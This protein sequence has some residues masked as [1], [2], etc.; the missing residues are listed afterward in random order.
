MVEMPIPF[1][2]TTAE[3]YPALPFHIIWLVNKINYQGNEMEITRRLL[4]KEGWSAT[5]LEGWYLLA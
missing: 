3:E 5:S 1:M 4:R 2:G